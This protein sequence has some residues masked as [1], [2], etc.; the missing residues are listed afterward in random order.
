[1]KVTMEELDIFEKRI[2]KA[3]GCDVTEETRKYIS[4]CEKVSNTIRQYII[5]EHALPDS[6]FSL[7][8]EISDQAITSV[9]KIVL[10]K[11]PQKIQKV[12]A[13]KMVYF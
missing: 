7:A 9:C 4:D 12:Y 8:Q 3:K 1:M 6:C 13:K 2:L 5:C 10:K 11:E